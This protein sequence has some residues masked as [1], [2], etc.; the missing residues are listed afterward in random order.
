MLNLLMVGGLVL[1][2]YHFFGPIGIIVAGVLL[3]MRKK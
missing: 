3:L 1:G 2:A